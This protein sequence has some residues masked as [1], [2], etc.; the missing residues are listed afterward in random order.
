M[1]LIQFRILTREAKSDIKNDSSD[2]HLRVSL[3]KQLKGVNHALTLSHHMWPVSEFMP[4]S[5]WSTEIKTETRHHLETVTCPDTSVKADATIS[6]KNN[7][8]REGSLIK[9]I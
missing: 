3:E 5:A 2:N 9:K 6:N 7:L 1:T 8:S 4:A